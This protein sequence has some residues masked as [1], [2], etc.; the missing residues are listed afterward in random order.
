[1][2][3]LSQP[4]G[5]TITTKL[6]YNF[7]IES[8]HIQ[9]G[10][11]CLLN[12]HIKFILYSYVGDIDF[13]GIFTTNGIYWYEFVMLRE[14]LPTQINSKTWNRGSKFDQIQHHCGFYPAWKSG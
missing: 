5:Q 10:V 7:K 1:M 4:S 8:K 2:D 6:H 11:Y 13:Y 14:Y 12:N 9:G 3:M